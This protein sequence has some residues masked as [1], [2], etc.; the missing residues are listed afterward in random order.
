MVDLMEQ[1]C[2]IVTHEFLYA[3]VR[4]HVFAECTVRGDEVK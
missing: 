3:D 4:V 2:V 1:E